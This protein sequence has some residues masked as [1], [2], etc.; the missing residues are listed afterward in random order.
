VSDISSISFSTK[1]WNDYLRGF[2]DLT[3]S[4]TNYWIG[5]NNI[6]RLTASAQYKL[7]VEVSMVILKSISGNIMSLVNS[8]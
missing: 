2:G 1:T 3:T 8:L 4:I 6:N 5:N 7:R